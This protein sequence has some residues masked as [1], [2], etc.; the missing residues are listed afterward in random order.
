MHASEA[1]ALDGIFFTDPTAARVEQLADVTGAPVRVRIGAMNNTI[2]YD[3]QVSHDNRRAQLYDGQ[4][5]AFSP[6]K[7]ILDFVAFAGGFHPRTAPAKS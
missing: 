1:K 4:L 2:Y 6:R 5:H 3:S 7:Y